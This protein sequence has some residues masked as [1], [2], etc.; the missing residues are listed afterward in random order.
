MIIAP[1]PRSNGRVHFLPPKG[2]TRWPAVAAW[3]EVEWACWLSQVGW[4]PEQI[5]QYVDQDR[6][7]YGVGLT[8]SGER[9]GAHNAYEQGVVWLYKPTP[10]GVSLHATRHSAISNTL[11]GGAAGGTK[12]MSARWEA[13]TLCMFP[14]REDLRVI[15]VR[16]E[17][18]EL[19]RTHLDK[20]DGEARRICAALGNPKAIKVTSQPPVA[21]F[22]L[23]PGIVSKI[24]FAHCQTDG[25]EEKYLSEDYDL[26][27]GDEA[28]HL[29]WKQIVGFQGRV[30]NDPKMDHIGRM[31]LTTN[32]GGPSH[33]ECVRYFLDKDITAA[34]NER[35]DPADYQFIQA[36][37]YD[38]PFYMD[39]DGTFT[40][41]EKRLYMYRPDRRQQLLEGDW[42]AVVD[43]FFT[44]WNANDHVRSLAS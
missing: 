15:F 8:P 25:D 14:F 41:Y 1:L 30:R 44:A 37:L 24:I 43:Q 4:T 9:A 36:A 21:T 35:Y 34:E 39:K 38:N 7:N 5:A 17:L 28:T 19:R 20:I 12:S 40:T 22:E 29:L 23:V 42:N 6:F 10:K 26:F 27:V 16:R 13:I 31:I 2:N 32:P 3:T 11:W 33:A 18:E